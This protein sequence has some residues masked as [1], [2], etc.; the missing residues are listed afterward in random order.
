[1]DIRHQSRRRGSLILSVLPC[2]RSPEWKLCE[3]SLDRAET[4]R[5]CTPAAGGPARSIETATVIVTWS[6]RA[7][8]HDFHPEHTS[9][10][11]GRIAN[12]K[13]VWKAGRGYVRLRP[14][15]FLLLSRRGFVVGGALHLF[16][17]VCWVFQGR[18][19]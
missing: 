16:F 12:Q 18:I 2:H 17:C 15:S 10:C 14:G 5:S 8:I 4:A 1:M 7:S 9:A 19:T 6:P 11:P 13:F 3:G